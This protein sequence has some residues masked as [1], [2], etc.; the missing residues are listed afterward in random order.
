V[1]DWVSSLKR[2]PNARITGPAKIG[3][4]NA[5]LRWNTGKQS[6][7]KQ[8]TANQSSTADATLASSNG[9]DDATAVEEAPVFNLS[10]LTVEFPIGKLSVITGP[11]GSGKT[12]CLTALLGEM[13]LLEGRS[14]L[15]KNPTDVDEST[16]LRNS[17]AYAAQTPWLQQQSIKDN[18]LFG[19][20]FDEARYEATLDA[21]A[22]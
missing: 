9:S 7:A 6:D 4:Q 10:N 15:P 20:K 1:P 21:C 11:T 2:S 18:I 17:V 22:L 14:F 16:G 13:E 12:A 19:E 8:D 5:T 3:F